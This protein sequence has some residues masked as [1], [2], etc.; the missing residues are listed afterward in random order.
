MYQT[1]FNTTPTPVHTD[2]AGH[3]V[4]GHSWGPADTD[5]PETA[6]LLAAKVLRV[7]KPGKGSKTHPD[8]VKAF[9]ATEA[10]VAATKKTTAKKDA[11]APSEADAPSA[12]AD[13][14]ENI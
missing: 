1:V 9:A 4:G 8:A 2:A 3:T 10:M 5:A 11:P 7:V 13:E 12:D 14:K 6:A